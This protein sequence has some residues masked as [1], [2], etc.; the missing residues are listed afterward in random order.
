MSVE[1]TDDEKAALKA[2]ARH[3][4]SRPLPAIAADQ[5]AAR[6]PR[7]ARDPL[8]PGRAEPGADA[9][10]EIAPWRGAGEE[11]AA[12]GVA[13]LSELFPDAETLLALE[14]EELGAA[15]LEINGGRENFTQDTFTGPIYRAPARMQGWPQDSQHRVRYAVAEA[16][17]WLE[18]SGLIM[19]D[20][21]QPGAGSAYYRILT[22]R[23]QELR[24]REQ[25][26]AYRQAA[27][28]PAGLVHPAILPKVNPPFLRGDY[29]VAVFAA[30]R[31][32]EV[33]V[34]KAG[35]F[36]DEELGV[37]LMRKAFDKRKGPLTDKRVVESERDAV[38]H[39][40]AGAIGAAKN[41][42]SHREVEMNRTEAARLILFASYLLSVVDARSASKP[43]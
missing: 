14:P 27:V 23:G 7:K 21:M 15:I 4:R 34:R 9:V 20:F 33:A 32:V 29:E 22:K 1:F 11:A 3:D 19:Q 26:E 24:T 30:F 41:P 37:P 38:A 16:F 12:I 2:A 31:A 39:L 43:Q 36:D 28:L 5:A 25:V 6:H 35:R 40:F 17:A 13:G 42:T 10:S 8:D 18:R